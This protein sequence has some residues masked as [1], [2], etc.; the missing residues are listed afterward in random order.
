MNTK[1]HLGDG[2][3]RVREFDPVGPYGPRVAASDLCPRCGAY[4]QCDCPPSPYRSPPPLTMDSPAP[5]G[6]SKEKNPDGTVTFTGPTVPL[7]DIL[8][9]RQAPPTLQPPD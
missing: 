1:E 8:D 6:W 7:S 9:A 5:L 4:W 3:M 2:T